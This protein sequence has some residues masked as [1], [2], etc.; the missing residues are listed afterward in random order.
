MGLLG[1]IIWRRKKKTFEVFIGCG[2]TDKLQGPYAEWT[3]QTIMII[4][5]IVRIYPYI[6]MGPKTMWMLNCN[7]N[8][9]GCLLEPAKPILLNTKDGGKKQ[10]FISLLTW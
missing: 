1:E 5:T 4:I 10:Q 8:N 6:Y 7:D 9:N 2:N 3:H